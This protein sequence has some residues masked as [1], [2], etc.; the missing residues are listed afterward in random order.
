M[1]YLCKYYYVGIYVATFDRR[2]LLFF[3][4]NRQPDKDET[5]TV[6]H[7]EHDFTCFLMHGVKKNT[8]S[9]FVFY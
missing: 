7:T 2:K 5:N 6:K 1:G 4:K 9:V 8:A 3:L